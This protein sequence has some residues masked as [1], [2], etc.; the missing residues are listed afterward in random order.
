MQNFK[1]IYG[2]YIF[3][4]ICV[5]IISLIELT[6][7]IRK[8]DILGFE[9]HVNVV[10]FCIVNFTINLLL[11]T[12]KNETIS[13][14]I[15]LLMCFFFYSAFPITAIGIFGNPYDMY[16]IC[17]IT[18]STIILQVL[19]FYINYSSKKIKHLVLL[20]LFIIGLYTTLYLTEKPGEYYI[21]SIH[22]ILLINGITSFLAYLYKQKERIIHSANGNGKNSI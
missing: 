7:I 11:S 14:N 1:L 10:L 18:M 4:I 12:K 20:V 2:L 5:S 16:G 13:R 3:L 6:D 19:I 8:Q 17:F 22:I 9:Y 21:F 15:I